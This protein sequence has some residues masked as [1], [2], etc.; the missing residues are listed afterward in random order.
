[1]TAHPYPQKVVEAVARALLKSS[2]GRDAFGAGGDWEATGYVIRSEFMEHAN[3]ALNTLWRADQLTTISAIEAQLLWQHA[4]SAYNGNTEG[5]HSLR[6]RL[7]SH[8]PDWGNQRS[9][10]D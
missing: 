10:N 7:A 5:M 6:L 9:T 2:E 3:T 1:M 4:V 8:A